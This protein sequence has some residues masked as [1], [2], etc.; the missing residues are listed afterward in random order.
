MKQ[1]T[2]QLVASSMTL[3]LSERAYARAQMTSFSIID[4][5]PKCYVEQIFGE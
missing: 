5:R 2:V 1:L 4:R 3:P